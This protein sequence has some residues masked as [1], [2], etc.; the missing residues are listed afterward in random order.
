MSDS[1]VLLTSMPPIVAGIPRALVLG[2]MPGEFSLRRREY[3]AHPRNRFWP[4]M[5][6]VLGVPRS[7]DYGDRKEALTRVGV[8][9]LVSY[10]DRRCRDS[11][12]A[13][14]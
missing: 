6:D 14:L 9:P 12:P 1:A 2:S 11:E 13:R 4:V 7:A 5:E 8:A 10:G 3:S